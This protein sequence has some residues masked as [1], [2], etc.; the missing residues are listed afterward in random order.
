MNDKFAEFSIALEKYAQ[1]REK[2]NKRVN[3]KTLID[4]PASTSSLIALIKAAHAE[5][6]KDLAQ[7]NAAREQAIIEQER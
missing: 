2:L 6:C 3:A 7:I 4:V 5:A 1:Q